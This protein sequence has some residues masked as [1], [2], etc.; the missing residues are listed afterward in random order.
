MIKIGVLENRDDRFVNDVMSRLQGYEIEFLS[1]GERSVPIQSDYRVVV[2]RLSYSDPYLKE[3]VKNFSLGGTYVINNPFSSTTINKILDIKHF[4]ALGI[5]HPKTIVLPRIDKNSDSK[6]IVNE[7]DWSRI[8]NEMSFP[9]IIKPFDGYAWTDVYRIES[10]EELRM[11][12][13]GMKNN[14]ILLVQNLIKYVDYYR[15]FC[16]NKKDVLISKWNPKPFDMG[17]YM[18]SDL[19]PI[20]DLR[21]RIMEMTIKLNVVLDL[22]MNAVEWCITE[23]RRAIVIDAFN[24]VPDIVPKHLP[25]SYYTWLVEK[26]SEC[27][28]DKCDSNERNKMI[29]PC[30]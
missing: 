20:E 7:P 24:E 30:R 29:F 2:D 26:F 14:Y 13:E 23:D 18:Q 21:D 25:E 12:Y 3:M 17:E 10:L 19:K 4:E 22:D 28:R 8:A 6:G 15:V 27:I 11:H 1:F 5:S 9:C 16:I